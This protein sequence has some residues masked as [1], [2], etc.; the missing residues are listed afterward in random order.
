MYEQFNQP[1]LYE[2]GDKLLSRIENLIDT[3]QDEILISVYALQPDRTGMRLATALKKA[4]KR[5]VRI[6][7]VFDNVEIPADLTAK[8]LGDLEVAGIEARVFRPLDAWLP[9]HPLAAACRNHVR[10]FVFDR[11][12]IGLGSSSFEDAQQGRHDLFLFTPVTQP[13]A[14]VAYFEKLW[15]L[16]ERSRIPQALGFPD[17]FLTEQDYKLIV[18][19]PHRT[20]HEIYAWCLDRFSRAKRRISIATPF[21]FPDKRILKS[22]VSAHRRGVSVQIF[23][24][25]RTDKPRYDWFR[26]IPLPWLIRHGITWYGTQK[27]FHA[28]FCIVDDAWMLGSA[29]FD[30]IGTERNF[31]LNAWGS[32]DGMR[33]ALDRCIGAYK[34]N[35]ST[36]WSQSVPRH[37]KLLLAVFHGL[38]EIIFKLK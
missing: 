38:A 28:K 32:D 23:T 30:I 37:I 34:E 8:I 26:V 24:P 3:A 31:E 36:A 22:L 21:F 7:I 25:L 35:A 12:I 29:N 17:G 1:L 33:E 16:A 9:F 4:A 13:D 15:I 6:R 11:R 10:L 2:D 14:I 19:G 27:Y 5:H 20:D 18:T